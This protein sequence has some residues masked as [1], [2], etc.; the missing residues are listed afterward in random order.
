MGYRNDV[1]KV[2]EY[3]EGYL[4]SRG[5]EEKKRRK[6]A[7]GWVGIVK[8]EEKK[9]IAH[10]CTRIDTDLRQKRMEERRNWPADARGLTRIV[11]KED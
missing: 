6:L 10:G 5:I 1:Q 7:R 11:R 3:I 8:T 2:N 4:S 9:R